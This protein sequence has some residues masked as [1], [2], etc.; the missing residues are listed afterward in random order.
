VNRRTFKF[1]QLHTF[2]APYLRAFYSRERAL[3]GRPFADQIAALLADGFSGSHLFAPYLA[4]LG[5]EARLAIA[6]ATPAQ[7]QWMIERGLGASRTAGVHEITRLQVERERPDVLYLSDPILFDSRFVRSLSF[8][9]ALVIGWRAADIPRGTDWSEFDLILS[10]LTVCRERAL[11]LGAKA[12]EHFH[13]GFPESLAEAAGANTQT[14]DVV[15]CGQY[16]PAHGYRNRLLCEVAKASRDSKRFSLDYYFYRQHRLPPD[17][18]RFDRGPRWGREMLAALRSGRIVLNAEIDLARGEAGNMRMFEA[19]GAGA[20]LLTEHQ[21]NIGEYFE[22]GK[23]LETFKNAG[24]LTEK[25]AYYLAHPKKRAGIAR[26]GQQRCLNDYGMRR[27]AGAFHELLSEYLSK[28][29]RAPRFRIETDRAFEILNRVKARRK[30]ARGTDYLRAR[31]F[32]G[33]GDPEAAREALKEELRFFPKNAE[34][35]ALLERLREPE[36]RIP[37]RPAEFTALFHAVEPYT[38]VSEARLLSL[39]KLAKRACENDLSGDF[40]EC[41]VA[42]GGSAAL[43]AAVSKKYS[44]RARRVHA[45]DSFTGMPDPSDLDTCNGVSAN[46]TGWGAGTCAA[47]VKSLLKIARQLGVADVV[48]PVKGDFTR[49]LPEYRRKIRAISLLHLDAD[50]YASTRAILENLFD[51]VVDDGFVQVDD[52]HYWEG[53]RRAVDQFFHA[54][55]AKARLRGIDGS[56]VWFLKQSKNHARRADRPA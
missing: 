41:G 13:P 3:A 47:P 16:S 55:N 29:H 56:G 49:T 15:F 45:F 27:R 30:P 34:A 18:E 10:H 1:L 52:Y 46:A 48:V 19:T 21:P 24:E 50:W 4:E 42:A 38:M 51:V 40:V 37:F 25:I 7:Q 26:R 22:A 31:Y 23:E 2:Y 39:Y 54:R 8:R 11:A 20:F 35:L 28:S 44:R 6:N 33:R 5:C 14:S 12:A 9:P 43:L 17:L 36:A 53:C 32:L